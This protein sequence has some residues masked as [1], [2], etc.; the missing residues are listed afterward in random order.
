M[1]QEFTEED[2]Q[3]LHWYFYGFNDALSGKDRNMDAT[4]AQVVAYLVGGMHARLGD[5]IPSLDYMSDAETLNIIK[6][7]IE[8][9]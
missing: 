5:D 2:K 3:L 1:R 9:S 6:N 7:A 4:N 8:H